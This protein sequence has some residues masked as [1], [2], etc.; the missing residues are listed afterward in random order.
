MRRVNAV[1]RD[2][3]RLIRALTP[4]RILNLMVNGCTWALARYVHIFWIPAGPVAVSIEPTTNCNLQCPECP[5]GLRSFTRPT[6]KTDPVL[7]DK[8]LAELSST[9]IWLNLYFQ[10]EPLLHPDLNKLLTTARHHRLYT[11]ISTNGHFLSEDHCNMLIDCGLDRLIISVD[12]L[13]Q[14][15]YQQYRRGGHLDIVMAGIDRLCKMKTDRKVHHPYLILQSL[16]LS[17]N[18]H[19]TGELLRML[20]KPGVDQISLKSAQ[21]YHLDTDDHLL[22][23]NPL[24][25]RYSKGTDGQYQS[26][27]RFLNHCFRFWNSVVIT[28][29]GSVLP[30]CFDKDASHILGDLKTQH[31]REV[32]RG[33]KRKLFMKQLFSQR[34]SIGICQ[35]C[36]E[37][38]KVEAT[39]KS[40]NIH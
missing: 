25:R 26:K 3:I 17:S 20:E 15:S 10:G 1:F 16:V 23:H 35:N 11:M 9:A 31:F 38:L 7:F 12:G 28:W 40:Q 32:W 5:S 33:E 22:P 21:F 37:G 18:E 14:E 30:C 24:F 13:D 39:P 8:W 2:R 19:Q 29:D 4:S 27:N 34:K 6:G 36:T